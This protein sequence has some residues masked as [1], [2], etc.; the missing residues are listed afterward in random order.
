MKITATVECH[1][2]GELPEEEIWLK[3]HKALKS[4]F[5]FG[6]FTIELSEF[7]VPLGRHEVVESDTPYGDHLA[8]SMWFDYVDPPDP[9]EN[10]E[11]S[12]ESL[13]AMGDFDE[14]QPAFVEPEKTPVE[15]SSSFYKKLIEQQNDDDDDGLPF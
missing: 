4:A 6:S 8:Q 2:L 9:Y 14:E 11:C 3:M 12:M 5:P 15:E 7:T 1:G 13:M 10:Y